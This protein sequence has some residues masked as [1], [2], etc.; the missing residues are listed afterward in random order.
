MLRNR[1]T[2]TPR[3]RNIIYFVVFLVSSLSS[4]VTS[5]WLPVTPAYAGDSLYFIHTDH[6]GS[7]VAITDENGE[8]VQQI[9]HHPYGESRYPLSVTHDPK[10][11]GGRITDN[12]YRVTERNYTSQWGNEFALHILSR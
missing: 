4:P 10:A 6:L 2:V 8:V 1:N 9:R 3:Y 11:E 7:T 5:Y 12:A